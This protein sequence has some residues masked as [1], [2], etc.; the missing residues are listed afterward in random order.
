MIIFNSLQRNPDIMG[1]NP[2]SQ[3]EQTAVSYV[4]NTVY[5]NADSASVVG[6][7]QTNSD[8]RVGVAAEMPGLLGGTNYA[9]VTIDQNHR[10]VL[11]NKCTRSELYERIDRTD[12]SEQ[13]RENIEGLQSA[14]ETVGNL[15][16]GGSRDATKPPFRCENCGKTKYHY[17]GVVSL[18]KQSSDGEYSCRNCGNIVRFGSDLHHVY[19]S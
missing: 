17:L 13:L 1:A 12:P 19:D 14:L 7:T 2:A 6:M 5:P 16:G 8:T 18:W 4:Q 3:L 11:Q 9:T 10:V 15:L